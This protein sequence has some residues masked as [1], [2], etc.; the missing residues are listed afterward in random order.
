VEYTGSEL[1][2]RVLD[3]WSDI[4]GMFVKVM[5]RDYKRA[6][7]EQAARETAAA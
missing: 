3:G 2:S 6:L 7:A 4:A 5:P 1:G